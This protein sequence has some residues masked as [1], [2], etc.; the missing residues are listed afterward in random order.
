MNDRLRKFIKFKSGKIKNFA[1]EMGW[2]TQ[3]VNNLLNGVGFGLSPVVSLAEK[4][5]ELDIRWLIT[6][7]GAMIV[8]SCIDEAKRKLE[9]LLTLEKFMPYMSEDDMLEYLDGKTDFAQERVSEWR[10]AW[11]NCNGEED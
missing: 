1:N 6:G 5:P 11:L 2:S 9:D 8:P 3:Y 4:F 7:N 10:E